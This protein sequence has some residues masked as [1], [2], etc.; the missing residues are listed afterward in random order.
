MST[1]E[2]YTT[3]EW[4]LLID[5]PS[6][7][8]T[9]VMVA[10]NSGLGSVKEAL[11][12]ASGILSARDGY[13]GNDLIGSLIESRLKDGMKSEIETLSGNPYKGMAPAELAQVV[14]EKC[15]AVS[16][17]LTAKATEAEAA[18]YKEWAKSVGLKVASA[19]KEGGFLGIGGE[20][21]SEAEQQVLDT[22][23]SSLA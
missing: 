12:I 15:L 1:K 8:G 23:Q 3:E 20:R 14:N 22:I 4:Q 7:V 10:G 9:A 18:G 21:V 17:L 6:M 11:A 13:E 5:V 2:D 19:A 16:E